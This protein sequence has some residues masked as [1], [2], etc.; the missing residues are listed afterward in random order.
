MPIT[1]ANGDKLPFEAVKRDVLIRKKA[2]T[3][4]K[5]GCDPAKRPTEV[6]AKYGIVNINKPAGPTSHQVS[7]YV[8]QILSIDKAGHSGTLDPN[9]TGVLPVA[10]GGGTRVVEA[11]LKA[12]KEY[13][14]LMHV[15]EE[16]SPDVIAQAA[17]AFVG[18]I[19]QLP[20][21][22]SAVKRQQ[23]FRTVYYLTI[24]DIQGRDVLFRVGCQAGTYIRKLVH[25]MGQTLGCGAH[26]AQLV[27][28]KAGPFRDDAMWT[29][30]DLRDAIWYWK[31]SGNDKFLREVIRPIEEAVRHLPKVWV[32]D[33]TV[34]TLCH[35]ASLNAPGIASVES[36]I[37]LDQSVAVMT[38]KG[39]L[40]SIGPSRMTS[41]DM[42]SKPRGLAVKSDKVFMAPGTYPKIQRDSLVKQGN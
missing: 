17:S 37:E 1:G 36:G 27:R 7:A 22:K 13:V 23:R 12:G 38:L 3:D 26:M 11:L 10:I 32:F 34:D 40:I 5:F 15:H 29:L 24:I 25:D 2:E 30:Q 41:Q 42:I 6:L 21:V 9:V 16:R 31:E 4:S 18:K 28:T 19:K 35:G 20:P 33:T 14:C 8:Q 39:E